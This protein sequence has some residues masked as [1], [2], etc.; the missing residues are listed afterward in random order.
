MKFL[1]KVL[2]LAACVAAAQS[3]QTSQSAAAPATGNDAV[4][5][6]AIVKQQ[7]GATFTVPEKFPTPLITAD[8][9]GDGVEDVAIVASSKEPLPDSFAFK[10]E[11]ADPYHAYF[12]FGNPRVTSSF[13]ADPQHTHH[14][15]V[16]FG[17]GKDAWRAVTPKG[18]FVLINVPFDSLE[19]GRMLISK[20]KPPIFVIKAV[21]SQIMDSS[22]WWDAKKK[23]WR[24][25]PGDTVQ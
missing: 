11:V 21:E 3:P 24:W 10:Y 9:D 17:S 12:G 20:K 22:V 5:L 16:I 15:L 6:A 25:E 13:S 23:H 18:K 7:F 4:Q 8:F 19:V 2:F 14:L 1:G